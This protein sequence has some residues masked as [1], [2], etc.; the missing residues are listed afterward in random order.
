MTDS[1]SAAFAV[2]SGHCTDDIG[3]GVLEEI[4]DIADTLRR[5][6]L[7][8]WVPREVNRISDHLSH[9]A[10]LLHVR[11]V[12]GRFSDLPDH[13]GRGPGSFV[14]GEDPGEAIL[15][16]GGG[17]PREI[18]SLLQGALARDGLRGGSML[19]NQLHE[20]EQGPHG[21]AQQRGESPAD[22]ARLERSPLV[23]SE[24]GKASEEIVGSVSAGGYHPG[25]PQEPPSH[26]DC[27]Q[28]DRQ[29]EP[30]QCVGAP[31][32]NA[33]VGGGPGPPPN[34]G[35]HGRSAGVALHLER[36]RSFGRHQPWPYQDVPT[37]RWSVCG[38]GGRGARVQV[39]AKALQGSQPPQKPGRVRFL[40]G[41]GSQTVSNH[42]GFGEKFPFPDQ[43]YRGL[44]WLEPR[45]L[46][47]T[48][49]PSRWCH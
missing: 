28:G 15:Q 4:F 16:A 45:P 47:R 29:V 39:P 46:Q 14:R 18:H 33:F 26:E 30:G 36:R 23:D 8:I 6:L 10:S 49:V 22:S 24:G 44:H 48:F 38:T 3:H 19:P 1:E 27:Y 9:F 32:G 11:E 31:V 37:G 25:R 17:P 5:S 34:Q 42:Q 21:L 41:T 13:I 12:E 2:N 35:G 20:G 40:Y 43:E 7:A